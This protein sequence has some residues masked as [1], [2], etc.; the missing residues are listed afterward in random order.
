MNAHRSTVWNH[1]HIRPGTTADY[2]HLE[3]FHYRSGHPGAVTRVLV[4]RYVGPGV[5]G[6]DAA[7]GMIAGALVE[8][9]PSLGCTLRNVA[10]P[11]RFHCGNRSLD[12]ARLNREMRTISR[13]VVHPIFRSVGLA[14]ELVRHAL[15]DAHTPYIEALAAMGRVHPFFQR[16]GMATFDRP[17][18]PDAV[19]VLAAMQREAVRPIDLV[20]PE[21]VRLTPFLLAEFRRF[22]RKAENE[23]ELIR[24]VRQRLL[25][26]PVY[27]LW[28][29]PVRN[30][31]RDR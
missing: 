30:Q 12:A 17:A 8:A 20:D 6:H 7:N 14:V 22:A 23:R 16:A 21:R 2:A 18:L 19:R 31:S 25:S 27:Y 5:G 1:L 28:S 13:V 26:Q 9:L 11:G 10:L 15:A 4:A 3:H 29:D 24:I